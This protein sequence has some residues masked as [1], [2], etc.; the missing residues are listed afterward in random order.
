[1]GKEF[2]EP[3]DAEFCLYHFDPKEGRC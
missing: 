2:Q 1:L 3:L